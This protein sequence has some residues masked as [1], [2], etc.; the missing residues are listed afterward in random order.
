M[1]GTHADVTAGAAAG[2]AQQDRLGSTASL[3]PSDAAALSAAVH[4]GAKQKQYDAW[5]QERLPVVLEAKRAE[6]Q[7][8]QHLQDGLVGMRRGLHDVGPEVQSVLGSAH[9]CLQEQ[10]ESLQIQVE[11]LQAQI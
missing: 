1:T 5:M 10:V 4:I 3:A 11:A 8:L 2:A 7:H 9:T 6:L